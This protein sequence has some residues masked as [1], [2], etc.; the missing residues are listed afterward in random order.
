MHAQ[1]VEHFHFL[2]VPN[3]NIGVETG[4]CLL[5]TGEVSSAWTDSQTCNF[6][7][8]SSEE[9]LGSLDNVSDND[10]ASQRENNV[11]VTRM[12]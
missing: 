5:S 7:I 3:Y 4:V 9:G 2:E 1:L 10:G 8:V 6:I 12:E 11:F